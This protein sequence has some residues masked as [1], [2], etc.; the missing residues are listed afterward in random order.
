MVRVKICGIKR[1]EDA[2]SAI[3]WGADSIG[4]LV[5]QRHTSTDFISAAEAAEIIR[6][7]PPFISKVMVTHFSRAEEILPLVDEACVDTLQLHGQI[8]PAE[9]QIIRDKRPHLRILKSLHII[10]EASV[11][12]GV[13][14]YKFVDGFVVDSLNAETGQIGGT[15][16]VHDWSI[17]RRVVSRY[18]IPVILAGGLTPENVQEAIHAV[19]PFAVDANSGLK[20]AA[21]FKDHAKIHAFI[22]NAKSLFQEAWR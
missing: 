22:D 12:S 8:P 17:S 16:M 3:R 14:Y 7:L 2:F 5:G 15:G 20:D 6:R 21:G 11:E 10:D 9:L 1:L 19:K 13:P 4:F 18:P